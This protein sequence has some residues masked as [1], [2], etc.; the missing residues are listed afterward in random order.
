MKLEAIIRTKLRGLSRYGGGRIKVFTAQL[1]PFLAASFIALGISSVCEKE[2]GIC[3]VNLNGWKIK[4][5]NDKKWHIKVDLSRFPAFNFLSLRAMHA[6]SRQI[7]KV[8]ADLLHP[9]QK[10]YMSLSN[11]FHNCNGLKE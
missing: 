7:A 9:Y 4:G 3:S 5:D 8:M 1:L 11:K 6:K 10:I 2:T